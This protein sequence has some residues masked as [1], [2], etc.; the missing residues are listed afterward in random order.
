MLTESAIH[1]RFESVFKK[2]TWEL[3]IYISTQQWN[4]IFGHEVGKLQVGA[5]Q[6]FTLWNQAFQ[7]QVYNFSCKI[8]RFFGNFLL[9]QKFWN[10]KSSQHYNSKD[11]CKRM[12]KMNKSPK[13]EWPSAVS[14]TILAPFFLPLCVLQN[15]FCILYFSS[16]NGHQAIKYVCSYIFRAL[17][18]KPP[19]ESGHRG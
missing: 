7:K 14:R 6:L 8:I 5:C 3:R 2:G 18:I 11:L 10:L 1:H 9:F 17:S 19:S 4:F 16:I 15:F 13:C 12:P